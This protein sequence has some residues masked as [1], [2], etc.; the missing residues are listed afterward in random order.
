MEGKGEE[1]CN[2]FRIPMPVFRKGGG[3]SIFPSI[4]A[5]TYKE[6]EE[7]KNFPKLPDLF[8]GVGYIYKEEELKIMQKFP[9]P[10][11]Y[12]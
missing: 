1:A 11:A 5:R 2:F 9:S 4:T 8:M 10:T 3:L 12:P 6:G 7:L